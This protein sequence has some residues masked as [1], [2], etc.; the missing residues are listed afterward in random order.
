MRSRGRAVLACAV[1]A[2]VLAGCTHRL[3]DFT[4][5]SSKN[6]DLS[7]ASQFKRGGDRQTGE[8]TAYVIIFIP[9]GIPHVKDAVDRALEKVPG[10]VALVDGV[11]RQKSMWFIV[12]G[13]NSIIVEGTPLIDPTL[14][15]A[16]DTRPSDFMV[17]YIDPASKDSRVVYLSKAEF[18]QVEK[19]IHDED[20]PAVES[21]LAT[22][23]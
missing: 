11:V 21:V 9:T 3:I 16:G 1:A 6:I 4:V 15:K 19:A 8:D 14:L 13:M 7:K 17:S 23:R 2:V 18:Q 22:H 5:I 12:F 20:S 10:A